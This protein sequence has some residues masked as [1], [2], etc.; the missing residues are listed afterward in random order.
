MGTQKPTRWVFPAAMET[1]E[2]SPGTHWLGAGKRRTST[3]QL[4]STHDPGQVRSTPTPTSERGVQA[5][6]APRWTA[7]NAQVWCTPPLCP[8]PAEANGPPY[9]GQ[10]KQSQWRAK[11][12]H[13]DNPSFLL[14]DLPW[15][16]S[17]FEHYL[18]YNL[19]IKLWLQKGEITWCR[20]AMTFCRIREN[21]LK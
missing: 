18:V 14:A 11:P 2:S 9:F 5:A 6:G 19:G 4:H 20:M 12:P 8:L 17:Q 1:P 13:G 7:A 3:P 15:Y 16:Q 21:W 10:R